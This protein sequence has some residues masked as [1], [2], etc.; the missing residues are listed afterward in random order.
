MY[1]MFIFIILMNIYNRNKID[2]LIFSLISDIDF[3][4]YFFFVKI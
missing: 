4:E 2:S 1:N 3:I